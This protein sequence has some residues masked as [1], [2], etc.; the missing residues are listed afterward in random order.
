M[1]KIPGLECILLID[2]EEAN[3]F[4]NQRIIKKAEIDTLVHLAYDSEQA[5][6]YLTNSGKYYDKFKYPQPDLIL[7]DINMPGTN[8]WGFLEKYKGLPNEQR[9][10]IILTMLTSSSNPDDRILAQRN[11]EVNSLIIK[12][13][14]IEKLNIIVDESFGK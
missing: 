10:K 1:K 5:L 9:N 3:H 14:T 12:P 11:I 8:D 13:L 4:I 2:D 6:E 7:I